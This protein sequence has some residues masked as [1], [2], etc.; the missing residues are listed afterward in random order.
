VLAVVNEVVWRTQTH[1]AR[2]CEILRVDR[3][4]QLEGDAAVAADHEGL[5]HPVDAP[6]DGG[7]AVLVGAGGGNGLP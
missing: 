4:D 7:A 1:P 6:L 3:A 2:A 5:R